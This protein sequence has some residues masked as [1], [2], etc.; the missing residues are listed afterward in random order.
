M[1]RH[2]VNALA[3]AAAWVSC[4]PGDTRPPPARV[5]VTARATQATRDGFVTSDG[6]TLT[7]ERVA[8]GIGDVDI[9]GEDCTDYGRADYQWLIDF[10]LAAEEKVGTVYGLGTCTLKFQVRVPSLTR[11]VN[12]AGATDALFSRMRELDSDFWEIQSRSAVIVAG[13]ASRDDVTKTFDWALRRGHEYYRCPRAD[14]SGNLDVLRLEEPVR[15][16]RRVE[17]RAEEL[18]RLTPSDDA[19]FVFD[20]YA[21]ADCNDDGVITVNELAT[22]KIEDIEGA[23]GSDPGRPNGGIGGVG[24]FTVC[25]VS[26]TSVDYDTLG[27]RVYRDLLPRIARLADGEACLPDVAYE[28]DD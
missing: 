19:P 10:E 27:D 15:I 1:R 8:M 24:G 12:G 21:D 4:L 6:W 28:D 18:F 13:R 7:F 25:S 26:D 20:P 16:N 11:T 3:V 23:G 5:D 2:G 22:V 14:G 17:I 9:D